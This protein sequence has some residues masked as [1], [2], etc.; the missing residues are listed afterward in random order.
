MMFHSY[1]QLHL[2]QAVLDSYEFSKVFTIYA[3]EMC[4][5]EGTFF[6]SPCILERKFRDGIEVIEKDGIWYLT[7]TTISALVDALM[8]V[9]DLVGNVCGTLEDS[10]GHK[11]E[12]LFLDPLYSHFKEAGIMYPIEPEGIFETKHWEQPFASYDQMADQVVFAQIWA[13]GMMAALHA[14]IKAQ[15]KS[16]LEILPPFPCTHYNRAIAAFKAW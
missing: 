8:Q 2:A 1:N 7:S 12:Y 4:R 9:R 6:G 5:G 11:D 14:L 16:H 3:S 13:I 10:V 15:S